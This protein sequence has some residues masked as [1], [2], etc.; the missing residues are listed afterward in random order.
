MRE[1]AE[2]VS[3]MLTDI[4][5]SSLKSGHLPDIWRIASVAPYLRD[6]EM[7]W[8]TSFVQNVLH[9]NWAS[10]EEAYIYIY[11][12]IHTYIYIIYI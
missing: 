12:Y 5:N 4:L 1:V 11:T 10:Y 3:E 9:V 7:N 8:R 2:Q 6:S